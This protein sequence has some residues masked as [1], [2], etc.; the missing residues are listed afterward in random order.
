MPAT[1][2]ECIEDK[3][4]F[5]EILDNN[6]SVVVL[7]FGADWCKPCKLIAPLIEEYK[8][9]LD[10]NI[11][12]YNLDVD[13]NFEIYAYLKS[14]RM[15]SGIPALLAYKANNTSFAPCYSVTGTN[16]ESIHIFFNSLLSN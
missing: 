9:K 10:E 15:V 3:N 16:K 11:H 8:N 5:Q 6:K 7:K 13:D 12:F 14:K 4:E 1:L 2:F